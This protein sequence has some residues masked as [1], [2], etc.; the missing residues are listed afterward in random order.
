ML[1][2]V[3]LGV[4]RR[5]R[6]YL[7]QRRARS[8][9]ILD[10]DPLDAK[11]DGMRVG[12]LLVLIV[13]LVLLALAVR[14][15]TLGAAVEAATAARIET[16]QAY[17]TLAHMA[18]MAAL[19]TLAGRMTVAVRVARGREHLEALVD[20]LAA[21]DSWQDVAL[22]FILP[23]PVHTDALDVVQSISW[24]EDVRVV[25]APEPAADLSASSAM[26][27]L[28]DGALSGHVLLLG[29]ATV[30]SPDILAAMRVMLRVTA[31][32]D[33]V[34]GLTAADEQAAM[35][36]RESSAASFVLAHELAADAALGLSMALWPTDT[37]DGERMG[38]QMRTAGIMRPVLPR[39]VSTTQCAGPA[40]AACSGD[41]LRCTCIGVDPLLA[42]RWSTRRQIDEDA[43][44]VLGG[45]AWSPSVECRGTSCF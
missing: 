15:W 23:S 44:E 39:A 1:Q 36:S 13:L 41:V 42:D 28:A 17:A 5:L 20:S 9:G 3:V 11:E 22:V 33:A 40:L 16:A 29:E 24:H 10:V 7:Y 6:R 37:D 32:R 45:T 31:A 25:Y 4:K 30:V 26:D 21:V 27:A 14:C 12:R 38:A 19:A 43:V 2:S 34:L 18:N 35:A 8:R